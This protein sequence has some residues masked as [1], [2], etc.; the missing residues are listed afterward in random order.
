MDEAEA[1]T[2]PAGTCDYS[3]DVSGER[4][5]DL[6]GDEWD[7]PHP[8]PAGASTCP[9]HRDRPGVGDGDP[10]DAADP[11]ELFVERVTADDPARSRFIGAAFGDLDLEYAVVRGA[12][13][14]PIDCREAA[15]DRLD[16]GNATVA[17][18]LLL[19]AATVR[20]PLRLDGGRFEG[21]V[22]LVGA[23]I[24][25]RTA[26][27]DATFARRVDAGH[28]RF[29]GHLDLR[30]AR[31]ESWLDL[32]EARVEWTSYARN[33]RFTKGIYGVGAEFAELADFLNATFDKV[34]NFKEAT[35]RRG[36][37][38]GAVDAHNSLDFRRATIDGPFE[39]ERGGAS[40]SVHEKRRRFDGAGW[41]AGM[42]VGGDVRFTDATL[43]GGLRLVD[44]D[45]GGALELD[46]DGL[47]DD[48]VTEGNG[49]LRVNCRDAAL[50]GGR[51]AVPD[52]AVRVD[53]RE[54]ALGDVVIGGSDPF[55]RTRVLDTTFDGFDF[56]RGPHRES[57]AARDYRL[58]PRDDDGAR[59]AQ[60]DLENTYLKAKNGAARVG[61]SKASAEFFRREMRAR[62]AGYRRRA[63]DADRPM[64][65]RLVAGGRYLANGALALTAG[66][67]ERPSRTVIASAGVVGLFALVFAG[68]F[69]TRT[70]ANPV[71][72]LLY[73][74][75]S[76]IAF[77]VGSP[78]A[79]G[80][81]VQALSA[82][83][84]FVGAFLIALFV[85]TLTRSVHR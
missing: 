85:F 44:A 6:P 12:T 27:E 17:Q 23:G 70:A 64:T 72:P 39:P 84:G 58:S 76:F 5:E 7:C 13:N 35:F 54:A 66:Y 8:A 45:I 32:R 80:P 82:L 79:V 71:F 16:L 67:G 75:Q 65:E 1:G 24:A 31:F 53:L 36:C 48:A 46:P 63:A 37:N 68:V 28:A 18:P 34:G 60:A 14:H 19:D 81:S 78:P 21:R 25:G 47:T 83:E 11:A 52:G 59:V 56:G 10:S 69:A 77:L 22:S 30:L 26:V 62:R 33:A 41:F 55:D 20:G 2:G 43:G 50:A 29:G 74:F 42:T 49:P 15:F 3:H 73:S 61:A 4:F 38:F 51:I 9:F 57:L 40:G